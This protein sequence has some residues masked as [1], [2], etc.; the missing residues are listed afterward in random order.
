MTTVWASAGRV[1]LVWGVLLAVLWPHA[2]WSSSTFCYGQ[3]VGPACEPNADPPNERLPGSVVT[4]A[5]YCDACSTGGADGGGGSC[6]RYVPDGVSHLR[7][8]VD[9]ELLADARF[10]AT[11]TDCGSS[12]KIFR[13]LG[14]IRPGKLH[15]ISYHFVNGSSG[16]VHF[17]AAAS[18][19]DASRPDVIAAADGGPADASASDSAP[20]GGG[21]D[22]PEKPDTAIVA[23]AA[24]PADDHGRGCGCMVGQTAA[25]RL[26]LLPLALA[27]VWF[28]RRRP[29]AR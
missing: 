21:A 17:Q 14:P 8:S 28:A 1:C 25:P 7:A 29:R 24:A 3:L 11:E 16:L 19:V 22:S 6:T 10:E 5:H 2:A 20:G 13:Y 4:F 15:E 27:T 18:A 26:G 23:D 12:G 9:G